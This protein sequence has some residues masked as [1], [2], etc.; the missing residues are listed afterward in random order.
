MAILVTGAAGFIGSH[1]TDTLLQR[2][3]EVV[4]L[5]NFDSFYDRSLKESNLKRAR[6]SDRFALV[7]ADL[8]DVRR[9]EQ[10]PDKIDAIVH[11]AALPG[12]RS[13][14]AKPARSIEVNLLGTA[15]LLKF[16]GQ[17]GITSFVFAS[18][19]SVYGDN[20]KVP[21]SE[22]DPVD[23][24]ISP[25]AVSKRSG[26]L[27]CRTASQLDG[28]AA[29]CLRLFTVYGPRQRPDLAVRKFAHLMRAGE[30]IPM[31]GDGTT[32]R[33]YTYISDALD[34][35]LS[36]LTWSRQNCADFEI[37]N[38]GHSVPVALT[39][40]IATLAQA[41]EVIPTLQRL[42]LQA[43]EVERTCAD[44]TKARR[45]LGYEPRVSF[46]EGIARFVKWLDG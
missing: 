11:L 3:V 46:D 12:V 15:H 13:S 18:S 30:P 27:L 41:L 44:L 1:L 23:R 2:G 28:I 42:P 24:P 6:A 10:L 37:V 8:L 16:A 20:A 38:L 7:E 35:I 31:F 22:H 33:D 32:S 25:Y 45:L 19:S 14:I 34:G 29:M 5:D 4:G 40:M 21:F 36:A 9:L 43:G 17:R 39:K 26:E